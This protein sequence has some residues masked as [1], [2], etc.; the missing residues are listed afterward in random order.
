MIDWPE[1][2]IVFARIVTTLTTS[3]A[4]IS[5]GHSLLKTPTGKVFP[6]KALGI[7]LM[8]F[9]ISISVFVAVC[10]QVMLQYVPAKPPPPWPNVAELYL[11]PL[12]AVQFLILPPLVFGPFRG[13]SFVTNIHCWICATTFVVF[14]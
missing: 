7:V 5:L 3:L 1:T 13:L 10:F 8:A 2:W 6:Y 14:Y 4:L 12:L 11:F 9:P